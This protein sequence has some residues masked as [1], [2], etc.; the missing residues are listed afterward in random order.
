MK[1]RIVWVMLL[2]AFLGVGL[3]PYAH[4]Q[5]DA[6]LVAEWH[7]D[8]GSGTILRDSS[9]NGYD[10]TI[11]GATWVDGKSGKALSFDGKDDY[12]DVENPDF[13][14]NTAGSISFWVIASY[15]KTHTGTPFG[16]SDFSANN[17]FIL[18][19]MRKGGTG[20]LN[21]RL[22]L[23]HYDNGKYSYSLD[24]PEDSCLAVW[25]VVQ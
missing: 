13:L 2:I 15:T 18:M 24:T 11:Y 21:D 25:Q 20:W 14:S 16:V 12:V 4:A 8:E 3:F 5:S 23:V 9:G 6:G 10:G 7:F 17:R 19:Y 22:D 1:S